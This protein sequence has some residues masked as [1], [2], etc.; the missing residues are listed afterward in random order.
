[1]SN[2]GGLG[3]K[4]DSG[5]ISGFAAYSSTVLSTVWVAKCEKQRRDER[6]QALSTHR[7]VRRPLFAQSHILAHHSSFGGYQ[8]FAKI[9]IGVS[10]TRASNAGEVYKNAIFDQ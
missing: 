2:A 6:R 8:T 5:R 4:R 3:K 7:G 1:M 10:L 9:P